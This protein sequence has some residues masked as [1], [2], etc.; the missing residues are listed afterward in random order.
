M[1]SLEDDA[2]DEEDESLDDA[3][4]DEEEL[5]DVLLTE[6]GNVLVDALLLKQRA[7][8]V[9]VENGNKNQKVK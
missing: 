8:A 2:P 5:P 7:F 1:A 9:H 6:A 4:T 3:T